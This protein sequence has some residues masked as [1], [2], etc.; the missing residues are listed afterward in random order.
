[1]RPVRLFI[2]GALATDG[3]THG[4]QIRQ[5]A[6]RDQTEW[7]TE[8]KPGSLYSALHR[9]AHEGL[10]EVDRTETPDNSPQ[11]TIYRITTAGRQALL[12]QR[13]EALQR[14]IVAT[15]PLDLALRYVSDLP[16]DTLIEIVTARH[17][18]LLERLSLHEEAY[19]SSQPYLEGLEPIT[20]RHVLRRL[21]T[22]VQWH[23]QLLAELT[24]PHDPPAST[25][26]DAAAPAGTPQE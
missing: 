22:E 15:D 6:L 2:L 26:D 25:S 3:P 17:T 16:A 10:V 19:V 23:E 18:A 12:A 7:W 14:V 24:A 11:R 1:M 13:D 8:V 5:N 9:M 21:R 4:Y 20:F